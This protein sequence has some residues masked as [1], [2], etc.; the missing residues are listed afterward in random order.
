MLHV[1]QSA[2][3]QTLQAQMWQPLKMGIP[4][5]LSQGGSSL[6]PAFQ[7]CHCSSWEGTTWAS[8]KLSQVTI[9][10]VLSKTCFGKQGCYIG[11]VSLWCAP[12]CLC[13]VL[14]LHLLD[15]SVVLCC[16]SSLPGRY[17]PCLFSSY[18]S[19][20]LHLLIRKNCVQKVIMHS[21]LLLMLKLW[22]WLFFFVS[23]WKIHH[24]SVF[25][26]YFMSLCHLF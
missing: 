7:R 25:A 10:R 4:V 26:L 21:L 8:F 14:Y 24:S 2:K 13:H 17:L 23:F 20:L 3:Y 1:F 9:S 6:P 22:V 5:P 16:L 15:C 18:V 12:W 11:G 19:Q